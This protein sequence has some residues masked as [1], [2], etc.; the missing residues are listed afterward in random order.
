MTA[1]ARHGDPCP[2]KNWL[3]CIPVYAVSRG[4]REPTPATTTVQGWSLLA[5]FATTVLGLVLD[6][7]PVG[8]WAF[9]AITACVATGTLTFAQAFA[10]TNNEVIWLIVVSFFFA[11]GIEKT[12]LGQRVANL[13]VQAL[14]HSTLGLTLGLTAAEALLAPAMPSTSARAG[15]IFVPIIT[16]LSEASGSFPGTVFR[17]QWMYDAGLMQ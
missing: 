3:A 7:L 5:I 4:I 12:G 11:K 8:A 13:F 16:S 14:G 2:G 10:A 9:L 17:D 6:P 1:H 15:G